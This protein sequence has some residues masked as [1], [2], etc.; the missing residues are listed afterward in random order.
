MI[1][2]SQIQLETIALSTHYYIITLKYNRFITLKYNRFNTLKYNCFNTL[3]CYPYKPTKVQGF[4]ALKRYPSKPI[5]VQGFNALK[6][7]NLTK[8]IGIVGEARVLPYKGFSKICFHSL[9]KFFALSSTNI[10]SNF[11]SCFLQT[12]NT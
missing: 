9:V 8:P 4:N 1:K 7:E 6:Y 10:K 2:Y 12:G 3:K 5:G 11:V